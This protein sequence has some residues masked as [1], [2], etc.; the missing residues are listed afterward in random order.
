MEQRRKLGRSLEDISTVAVPSIEKQAVP[1][2][3]PHA[4]ENVKY[5]RVICITSGKG[6]T[7]KSVVTSNLSV[8]FA[9]R[10]MKTVMIDADFGLANLHIMFGIAPK[11][12][13]SHV[14]DEK[15]KI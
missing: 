7:G 10:R 1:A 8:C 12:N 3:K 9:S 5:A 14:L 11:H 15:K 6:G 2:V 13:I 4:Q